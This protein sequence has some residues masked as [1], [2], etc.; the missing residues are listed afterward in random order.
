MALRD[1]VNE[2]LLGKGCFHDDLLIKKEIAALLSQHL[3][4][5]P[6][7]TVAQKNKT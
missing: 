7:K 4:T 6:S 5:L 3:R 2:D 1:K